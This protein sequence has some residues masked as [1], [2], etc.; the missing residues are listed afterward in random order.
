MN[1][2]LSCTGVHF[3]NH[4]RSSLVYNWGETHVLWKHGWK[5]W[6]IF[7]VF[8]QCSRLVVGNGMR[9]YHKIGCK[10]NGLSINASLVGVPAES[11]AIVLNDYDISSFLVSLKI[12]PL[13]YF[14]H[15]DFRKLRVLPCYYQPVFLRALHVERYVLSQVIMG[16]MNDLHL[17]SNWGQHNLLGWNSCRSHHSCRSHQVMILI[18]TVFWASLWQTS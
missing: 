8:Q 9:V 7:N 18:C 3:G 13:L 11:W 6:L 14:L 10:W 4:I 16:H 2:S 15:S 5:K 17:V 12:M 1:L